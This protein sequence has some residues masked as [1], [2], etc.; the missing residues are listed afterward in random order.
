MK[1]LKTSLNATNDGLLQSALKKLSSQ[2]ETNNSQLSLRKANPF[3]HFYCED[4][5]P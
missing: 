2:I 3:S 1:D 5:W 4:Y